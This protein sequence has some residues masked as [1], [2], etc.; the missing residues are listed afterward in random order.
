MLNITKF[1]SFVFILASFS[2][3]VFADPNAAKMRIVAANLT[4]GAKQS[5]DP[6]D[7]ARILNTLQPDI[8]LIQE[9]NFGD[10]SDNAIRAFVDK[11][12]GPGFYYFREPGSSIPNGIISRYPILDA[13]TWDDRT[14]PNREFAWAKL[15]IPGPVDMWVIS[16]H[17]LNGVAEDRTKQ[18]RDLVARIQKEINPKE[19]VVLGGD[20][21]M[22]SRQEGSV[23]ILSS[24]VSPEVVPVDPKNN[25]NTNSNRSKPYDWVMPSRLLERFQV[26]TDFGGYSFPAGLV[27]DTRV[28]KPK[29]PLHPA[30]PGDSGVP[31]MQHM[32][33][34]K[35]FEIPVN[36]EYFRNRRR[37]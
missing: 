24:V 29:A 35:D 34:V 5:Y 21:N 36:A 17:L 4:S 10:N 9:F 32:P 3:S 28:F 12:F 26:P 15:D 16:L 14:S 11:V 13:G 6:G 25:P 27:F 37:K 31:G 30:R 23:Q 20:L 2:Q 22:N 8:V 7:G 18:A 1:L 33:V 19:Y